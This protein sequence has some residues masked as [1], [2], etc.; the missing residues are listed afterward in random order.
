MSRETRRGFVGRLGIGGE[1]WA[2]TLQTARNSA[3]RRTMTGCVQ[4]AR[5]VCPDVTRIGS[6]VFWG[7]NEEVGSLGRSLN[8]AQSKHHDVE[9]EGL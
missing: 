3:S 5:E 7:E 9:M 8:K 1:A 6:F 4:L 2:Q